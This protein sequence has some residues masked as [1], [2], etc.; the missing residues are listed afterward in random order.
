MY[1][2]KL[3]YFGGWKDEKLEILCGFFVGC[4]HD[5]KCSNLVWSG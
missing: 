2:I 5:D 3:V 4:S 1:K